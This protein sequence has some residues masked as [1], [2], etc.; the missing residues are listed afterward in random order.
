[1][2][3]MSLLSKASDI[4]RPGARDVLP[5]SSLVLLIAGLIIAGAPGPVTV[6]RA[7][8]VAGHLSIVAFG[9]LVLAIAAVSIFLQPIISGLIAII[10]DKAQG[11]IARS[12]SYRFSRQQRT[13]R[14][15]A[16]ERITELYQYEEQGS[17]D[18]A[19]RM[20]LEAL[21]ERL[22]QFPS[23]GRVRSTELGNVLAAAEENAGQAYGLDSR[24][25]LPRLEPLLPDSA[26]KE[27]ASRRADCLF[28]SRFCATLILGT[29]VSAALLASDGIW[30]I[31]PAVT[32]MFSWLSYKNAIAATVVYGETIR[33]QFELYR[34]LLYKAYQY[35]LPAS[36]TEEQALGRQLSLFFR[37]G[38]GAPA[39]YFYHE[40]RSKSKK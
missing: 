32:L 4:V 39:H 40:R 37:T 31:V 11:A 24:V 23:A 8:K 9:L 30:L 26:T 16:R 6:S 15:K 19:Q 7:L 1:M 33:V 17:I 34:L 21:A 36:F 20:E 25:A 13:R 14:D 3:I 35:P 27:L 18:D 22:R 5:A 12:I 28:A 10:Q 2:D 38:L 29:I